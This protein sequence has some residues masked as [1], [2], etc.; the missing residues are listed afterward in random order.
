MIALSLTALCLGLVFIIGGTI[1]SR[2]VDDEL[3]LG[4][5]TV[6]TIMSIFS[7]VFVIGT[8]LYRFFTSLGVS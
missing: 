4:M 1:I 8:L 7:V 5:T 6:G 3:G 2:V